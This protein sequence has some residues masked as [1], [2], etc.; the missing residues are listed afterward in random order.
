MCPSEVTCTSLGLPSKRTAD[1]AEM[2]LKTAFTFCAT[3]LRSF[4]KD[5]DWSCMFLEPEDLA[6][7]RVSSLISLMLNTRLGLIVQLYLTNGEPQ[8]NF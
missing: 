6:I 2:R 8:R 3:V 7:K 4:A 1:Y 5:I